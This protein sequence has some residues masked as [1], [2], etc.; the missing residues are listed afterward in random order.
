MMWLWW[1]KTGKNN[2]LKLTALNIFKN[3]INKRKKHS[4]RGFGTDKET[5]KRALATENRIRLKTCY[6]WDQPFKL[7]ARGLKVYTEKKIAELQYME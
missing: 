7:I 4:K 6:F 1:L 3:K 2:K 5:R